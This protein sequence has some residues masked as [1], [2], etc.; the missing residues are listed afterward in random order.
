MVAV[1]LFGTVDD[2]RSVA[3]DLLFREDTLGPDDGYPGLVTL[4]RQLVA[5]GQGDIL[6]D[7]DT[8]FGVPLARTP[9][10]WLSLLG[11]RQ[12]SVVEREITKLG[13]PVLLIRAN[14]DN[15]TPDRMSQHVLAAA[16]AASV[17]ATYIVLPFMDRE[18]NPVPLTDNGGNAHGFV[19]VERGMVSESVNWLGNHVAD[20]ALRTTSVREPQPDGTGN[21]PPLAY[22]EAPET[23]DTTKFRLRLDGSASQ[24]IDGD[25]VA[26]SWAQ[27]GGEPVTLN[28]PVSATPTF[29]NP[30]KP[31]TLSFELTV[32]D[33]R[34]ATDTVPVS[35][36]VQAAPPESPPLPGGTSA[37]SIL[38]M[39]LLS[40]LVVQSRHRYRNLQRD[41]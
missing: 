36:E 16:Q 10:N 28:D 39:L 4:N 20:V 30:R 24:D 9:R 2:G 6:R 26:W 40:G 18:G 25:I 8:F 19:G 38:E 41:Q 34:G 3:R 32:T 21:F 17:D 23:V 35:L 29:G 27:T 22:V 15:F 14:G 12:F 37:F 33:N 13:V 7:Y 11:P 1:G 31:T 5:N